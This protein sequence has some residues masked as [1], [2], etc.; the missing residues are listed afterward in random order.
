MCCQT[1]KKLLWCRRDCGSSR[2]GGARDVV[3][4]SIV[5]DNATYTIVGV[6][7][8]S[9]TL[10]LLDLP[11]SDV[12]LPFVV[13]PDE[14]TITVVA[15]LA[16]NA[17]VDVVAAELQTILD[18]TGVDPMA[19]LTATMKVEHPTD[20]LTYR[21]GLLMLS[22]A[23][24]LLLLVAC[25]NLAHLLLARGV[26]RERELAVRYALGAGRTRLIRL[27]ITESLIVA[28]AGG[29]LAIFVGWA[30]LRLLAASHPVKM[31]ALAH[32][33]AGF[34]LVVVAAAVACVAGIAIGLLTAL[35]IARSGIGEALRTGAFSSRA[36]GSRLRSTLVVGEVALSAVLLVGALLLIHAV[37]DLQ[38]T[39]L[40]F[41][42]H[43]LY[44]ISFNT[45]ASQ[46]TQPEQRAAFGDLLRGQAQ[47]LPGVE[48]VT[49][50][51]TPPTNSRRL[52][53]VLESDEQPAPPNAPATAV[54]SAV[55]APDFFATM[56]MPLI[57]GRTFDSRSAANGEI[58]ISQALA[59]TLWPD[60]NAV[61]HRFRQATVNAATANMPWWT[62]IGVAPDIITRTLLDAKPEPAMYRPIDDDWGAGRITLVVRLKTDDAASA[63]QKLAM[64]VRPG[65]SMPVVTGLE[66]HMNETAAEPR[67]TMVVLITF[68]TLAVVLAATG[69]Y[70]VIAYT[71]A[72]R[73][74][75]IGVRIVL[76]ASRTMIARLV[77]G[78]GLRLAVTGVVIGL[79][80]A[81]G[82]TRVIEH[83]LY[84]VSRLDPFSFVGGAALLV[85][86]S[87]L[88]CVVPMLRAT[89]VDPI[90][91][92]RVD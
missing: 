59:R 3:G 58:I 72:Q 82:A 1:A 30:G 75:E 73:T 7:P 11:R 79:I 42:A 86:I 12:W 41:D 60:G 68:A 31:F 26:A 39:R 33:T 24:A 90:V 40:G 88:A 46:L 25:I 74:R 65:T 19:G 4:K 61:G 64:A 38:R 81:M 14:R 62:V 9:L 51:D 18:R 29:A 80:G 92:V 63:L 15:R 35:R 83:L 53:A 27:L 10:P 77:I 84:G 21:R 57:A 50:A 47:R 44:S 48:A 34:S 69:L 2:F 22:G 56:R 78:N 89:S 91:A 6:A 16:P 23:V 49:L 36:R 67:F 17:S 8:S 43:G 28:V 66:E 71:V 37:Y 13:H 70:G 55:V 20:T 45:R 32:V 54:P 85:A 76:G 52:L 5:L 87:V